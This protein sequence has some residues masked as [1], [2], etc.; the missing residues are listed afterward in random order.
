L[1][2]QTFKIVA[3]GGLAW[4]ESIRLGKLPWLVHAFSTRRGGQSRPPCRGLNL[5][6]TEWDRRGQVELNRRRFLKQIGARDFDLASV[7][8][9]HSS[10]VFAVLQSAAGQLQ[11]QP[12]GI[13]TAKCTA[14]SP[15][16]GDGLMTAEAGILL[17]IRIADCLPVLLVDTRRRVIAAVHA[18]WRGA[19]DRIIEKA[20]GDLRQVFGC[21]PSHMIAALGPSIRACCYEVGE[22]VVEAFH[23]RFAH[24]DRFFQ[25][26]AQR[27]G[28][29]PHHDSIPFLS[30]YPPGHAPEH[31]PIARL[32]LVAVAGFQLA[33][34]GV[35]PAHVLVADLCTACR[36]DLFF[37]HR[38]EGGRTGRQMAVVG[39]RPG[40]RD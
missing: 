18:G 40:K 11:Y 29:A 12:S 34:A 7:R 19:L 22:E 5:G 1:G 13:E 30:A 20:V 4:L 37:S 35:K 15:P 39:I 17:T 16:A 2:R 6:M 10:H 33:S 3:R 8:Q 36:T 38:R 26:L 25:M 14:T 23:G 32:D 28:M 31:L 24:A 21:D 9:V 27:P